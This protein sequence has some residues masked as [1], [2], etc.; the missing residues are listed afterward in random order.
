MRAGS[1]SLPLIDTLCNGN[2][3]GCDILPYLRHHCEV[4]TWDLYAILPLVIALVAQE[5]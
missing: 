4:P 5:T 1:L 3:R 2:L